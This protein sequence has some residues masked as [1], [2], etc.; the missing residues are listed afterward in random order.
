MRRTK[1]VVP[2]CRH[3]RIELGSTYLVT[4]KCRE[5][6]CLITPSVI[7]NQVLLYL[8]ALKAARYGIWVHGFCFMSNHFHLVVTDPHGQL[9]VF[10]GTFLSESSKALQVAL[11]ISGPIWNRRRYSATQLLDL[12]AAERELAYT[13]TNPTNAELTTPNDWPGLSSVHY[14]VSDTITAKRPPMYFSKRYRPD[15]VSIDLVPLGQAY[16][17]GDDTASAR[18]VERLVSDRCELI[19]DKLKREGKALAGAEKV[20]RTSRQSKG[21]HPLGGLNPRFASRNKQLLAAAI[22][23]SYEFELLFAKA[24]DRYISGQT[25]VVFPPGTYGYRQQL[26][27]RVLR[28]APAA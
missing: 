9:P 20:L 26:G 4:Q 3:R 19:S 27:V 25:R 16:V 13:I 21:N 10:M 11:R 8:L 15:E 17:L 18:A 14:E 5:H 6:R 28:R 23:E 24:R 12:D 1:S 22:A 2:R 7:T